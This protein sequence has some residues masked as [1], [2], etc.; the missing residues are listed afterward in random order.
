MNQTTGYNRADG[1][2]RV[3]KPK[4]SGGKFD[5]TFLEQRRLGI[6]K[7]CQIM[8]GKKKKKK[9]KTKNLRK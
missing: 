9:L 8:A 4:G 3:E 5:P 7:F 1:L 6:D 2:P